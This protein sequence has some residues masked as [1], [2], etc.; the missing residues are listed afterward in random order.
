MGGLS[1]DGGDGLGNEWEAPSIDRILDVLQA[2]PRRD[3][4]AFLVENP[5]RVV[6]TDEL[7]D[8]VVDERDLTDEPADRRR[9]EIVLHHHHLPKLAEEGV[10]AF[11]PRSDM[12]R[13]SSDEA[14]EK[15]HERIRE[16]TSDTNADN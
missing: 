13:Y 8:H 16:W 12:L 2:A 3:V 14:V 4:L 6:H 7:V 10:I 5:N 15:W 1:A 11:D 9:V